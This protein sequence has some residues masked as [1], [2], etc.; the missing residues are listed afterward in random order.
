[1]ISKL[2]NKYKNIEFAFVPI[3]NGKSYNDIF[4]PLIDTTNCIYISHNSTFMKNFITIFESM[5]EL[6]AY[7]NNGFYQLLSSVRVAYLLKPKMPKPNSAVAT[8][9]TG[10]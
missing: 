1:L 6:A 4:R 5:D 7:F 8:L 2:T 3:F 9:P 10:A